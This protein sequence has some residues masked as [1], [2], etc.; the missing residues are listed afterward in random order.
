MLTFPGGQGIHLSR[1]LVTRKSVNLSPSTAFRLSLATFVA[2]AAVFGALAWRM[3]D[4]PAQTAAHRAYSAYWRDVRERQAMRRPPTPEHHHFWTGSPFVAAVANWDRATFLRLNSGRHSHLFD[5]TMPAITQVGTAHWS[6]VIVLAIYLL[7]RK[8]RAARWQTTA[9]LGLGTVVIGILAPLTKQAIPR[10]RP[11][12]VFVDQTILIVHPLF[13]GS[14]PSGHSFTVFALGVLL[15]LR[16]PWTAPWALGLATLIACSRIAVGVHFP[17]DV[18]A[19][20]LLGS[21][22]GYLFYRWGRRW[23]GPKEPAL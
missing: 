3:P 18:I 17:I 16:H 9:L 23:D 19:G 12:A 13:G 14:F 6:A 20:A 10:L 4:T 15:A 2:S 7:A 8:R 11:P 21:L 5:L 1:P 22:T